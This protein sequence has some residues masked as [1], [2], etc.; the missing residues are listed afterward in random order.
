MI[1]DTEFV[2]KLLREYGMADAA[3]ILAAR[4]A[5][6][7]SGSDDAVAELIKAGVVDADELLNMLAQQYG[8]EVVDLNGY[9]IPAEVIAGFRGDYARYYTVIPVAKDDTLITVAMSDPTNVEVLG[10][11]KKSTV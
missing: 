10:H 4:N 7:E 9:K 5:A 6:L 2:L 11:N 1:K 8:M 3:Q